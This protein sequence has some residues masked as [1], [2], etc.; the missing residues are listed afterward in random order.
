MSIFSGN[1]WNFFAFLKSSHMAKNVYRTCLLINSLPLSQLP[2][3]CYFFFF[4]RELFE[5]IQTWPSTSQHGT[6]FISMNTAALEIHYFFMGC[7]WS[8][9]SILLMKIKF[10]DTKRIPTS[11]HY[12]QSLWKQEVRVKILLSYRMNNEIILVILKSRNAICISG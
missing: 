10:L 9:N 5:W 4:L 2:F 7:S 11:W 1:S 8:E 6:T 12:T 3:L